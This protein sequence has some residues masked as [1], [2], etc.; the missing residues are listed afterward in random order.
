MTP[1]LFPPDLGATGPGVERVSLGEGAVLLRGAALAA[2]NELAAAVERIA[3]RAPFRRMVTPGGFTMSVAMTNCGDCG[4]VTDRDGY[5]YVKVDPLSGHKWPAMPD[6]LLHCATTAAAEAGFP[7]F[8]PDAC[9]VNRYEPGARLSLHQDRD[10]RDLTQPVVSISLGLP[11]I[12][13]FGGLKRADPLRRV[14]LVH[15]DVVVWGGPARLRYH[16]VPTLKD[17]EHPLLG[18]QRI[19]FTLRRAL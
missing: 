2:A 1:E 12:F 5:R 4:W 16:G 9:L 13:Q 10:E 3:A 15:G 6:V 18:R 19:N 7:G 14:P 11:A 17:G 8:E